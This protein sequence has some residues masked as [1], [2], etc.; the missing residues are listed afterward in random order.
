[1]IDGS[2]TKAFAREADRLLTKEIGFDAFV[3]NTKDTWRNLAQYLMRRWRT[4]TD[5]DVEDVVQELYVGAFRAAGRFDPARGTGFA[6]YLTWNAC[7]KAKKRMHKW[8][9]AN[10]HGSADRNP[11]RYAA[12]HDPSGILFQKQGTEAEQ[13]DEIDKR[14]RWRDVAAEMP[15]RRLHF[16]MLALGGAKGDVDAAACALYGDLDLRLELRLGSEATARRVVERAMVL[17]YGVAGALRA[18]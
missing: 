17:A 8:R 16:A 15:T 2:K 1:M 10:L 13:V 18:A 12:A 7:D 6:E 3:R 5:V 4:P 11:G 9:G 14:R